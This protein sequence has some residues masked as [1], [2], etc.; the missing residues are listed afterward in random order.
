MGWVLQEGFGG[1]AG[2]GARSEMRGWE[3]YARAGR[4]SPGRRLLAPVHNGTSPAVERAYDGRVVSDRTSDASR[5]RALIPGAYE[6]NTLTYRQLGS[7]TGPAYGSDEL[8]AGASLMDHATIADREMEGG[9]GVSQRPARP[10]PSP[11]PAERRLP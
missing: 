2:R 7:M 6:K 1:V 11:Q 4:S 5:A 8:G 3:V 10:P 9:G